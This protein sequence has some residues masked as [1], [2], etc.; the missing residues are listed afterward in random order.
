MSNWRNDPA[1]E[2]QKKLIEEM[3]EFSEYPLPC[4]DL[5]C[6]TKGECCDYIDKYIA[7]AHERIISSHEDAGDRI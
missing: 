1:T 5:T 3:W 2:K 4:F 6:A 7:L